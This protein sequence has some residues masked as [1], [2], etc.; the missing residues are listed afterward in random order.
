MLCF[1]TDV[2]GKV[3]DLIFAY[4]DIGAEF[5]EKE[6]NDKKDEFEQ[7]NLIGK[8]AFDLALF[9]VCNSLRI[10]EVADSYGGGNC[11]QDSDCECEVKNDD[12]VT[13]CED[14][15]C[16]LHRGVCERP[17][18][19]DLCTSDNSCKEACKAPCKAGCGSDRTTCEST[20][21]TTEATC[22][23]G[24]AADATC[25]TGCETTKA[26]CKTTCETTETT[27]KAAGCDTKCGGYFC[28][29][30]RGECWPGA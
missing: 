22:K 23:E 30:A 13:K 25:L 17:A 6:D 16:N 20:C 4:L 2:G 29:L 3:S 27:C 5:D 15:V 9:T 11:L 7:L 14:Y 10:G 8:S 18:V 21:D 24:C 26:T 1:A 12:K 28:N 19:A